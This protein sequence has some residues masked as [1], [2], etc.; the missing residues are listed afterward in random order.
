M[1]IT[2]KKISEEVIQSWK[3]LF[4]LYSELKL[5][6]IY[7]WGRYYKY[8]CAGSSFEIFPE[9]GLSDLKNLN[10]KNIDWDLIKKID[11][12]I[13]DK[14][15]NCEIGDY[16]FDRKEIANAWNWDDRAGRCLII[17]KNDNNLELICERCDSPE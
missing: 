5:L 12:E 11:N 15:R 14:I 8:E 16:F 10:I 7:A 17:S 2:K 6:P 13:S 1:N 3:S 9:F 4:E